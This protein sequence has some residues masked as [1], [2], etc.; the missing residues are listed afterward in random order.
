MR[1]NWRN[2]R[3][4]NGRY[5]VSNLGNVRSVRVN[6][7]GKREYKPIAPWRNNKGYE[8]VYLCREGV[9][10]RLLVHRIVAEAFLPNPD[11]LPEV[12]HKDWITYNNCV[13]NLEWCTRKYNSQY[14]RRFLRKENNNA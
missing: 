4:Y 13:D 5:Q 7:K 14:Q 1:E 12:N 9:R 6:R 8:M 10:Q 2:V 3:G 11:R